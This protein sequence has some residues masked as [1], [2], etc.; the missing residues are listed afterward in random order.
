LTALII[1]SQISLPWQQESFKSKFKDRGEKKGGPLCD[2]GK[3]R[4]SNNSRCQRCCLRCR[5]TSLLSWRHLCIESS[6][7]WTD[8]RTESL[9]YLTSTNVHYVHLGR[10]NND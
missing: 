8:R 3:G 4:R 9:D 2:R 1:L 6:C 10:D 5:M 7:V